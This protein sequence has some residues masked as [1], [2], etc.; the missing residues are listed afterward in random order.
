MRF[1]S[2]ASAFLLALTAAVGNALYALGQ[3]KATEHENPFLFGSIALFV[4]S[5]LLTV[6]AAFFNTQTAG[7]YV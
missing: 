5:A 4:G 1:D 2:T 3:K 6:I 7:S